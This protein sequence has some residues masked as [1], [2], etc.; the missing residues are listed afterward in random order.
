MTV[1][2]APRIALRAAVEADV[3]AIAAIYRREVLL[4]SAS[5]E[6]EPPDAAAM[7]ER[8]RAVVGG[9]YPYLVALDGPRIAGYAYASAY[10]PREGYRYT[11][12]DSVYVA[13]D[14]RGKGVGTALLTA[15]IDECA[16]R[17]FRQMVAVIGGTD[18][19]GSIRLHSAL[20]FVDVGRLPAIGR[21]FDRW[22][23]SVLMQRALGEGSAAPPR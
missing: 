1:L 12:E 15:L 6:L 20:G 4:Q 9:G 10:R 2:A 8:F 21:K 17:G 19:H 23:D 5:W 14:A 16:D 3:P 18:Q 11:V 7:L 13:D 22:H